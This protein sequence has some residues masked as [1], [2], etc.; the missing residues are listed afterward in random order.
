MNAAKRVWLA[1]GV[2]A[3]LL[4]GALAVRAVVRRHKA[5]PNVTET[6]ESGVA[7]AARKAVPLTVA[8]VVYDGKLNTGWDDWGW[9]PHKLGSG[10]AEV[11]FA[12]F[13]GI[14]LHHAELPGAEFG[15]VAFRYK[16]PSDWGHFMTVSLRR[17]GIPDDSFPTVLIDSRHLA[18]LEDGWREVLV[19]WKELNP[20]A[21]AF[22]RIM[23]GSRVQLDGDWVSLD[24]IVLTAAAGVVSEPSKRNAELRVLCKAPAQPINELIYGGSANAWE[25]GQSAQRFGGNPLSRY[26]WEL[27]AWNTGSDWY[28]ENIK[29]K[30]TLFDGIG[31]QLKG[32]HRTALV[33]P[34]LGWVA[35][36]GVS[37][38]FP[39]AKFG[40]QR[41]YDPY[42][43]EAGDGARPDGTL[44]APGSPEQTSL[45]APPELIESW[46]KKL[47]AQAAAAGHVGSPVDIYILDNEPALW[48]VTHRD[49]HPQPTSYD[50]L[51]DR[52]IKYAS[53]I[54]RADPAAVIAGPAE[55]G[56]LG[57]MNSAVDRVAGY[58]KQPDR[59]AHGGQALVAWYLKQLADHEKR[60]GTRLLDMLD[61]H[62]YPQATGMYGGEEATDARGS[63]L[64]LRSTRSLWDITYQ[65]ESWIKEA[66][67]LIPR[68]KDWVRENYPGLKISIGEWNFGAEGHISGGLAT[69][70][71]LGR[72]GQQ[73][74]DAAFHWGALE[75][76][77][78][79]YWAFRAFRNFDGSGGRF[80]DLSL[81][82]RESENLSLFASRDS[83]G[84][85]LVLVAINRSAGS[86]ANT[87]VALEGCGN[88][89]GLRVFKYSG[90][91]GIEQD[92]GEITAGGVSTQLGAY[93][94]AVFDIKLGDDSKAP[95]PR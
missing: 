77:K 68:M 52:T 18:E 56:W 87:N 40:E 75:K 58:D 23:I 88:V 21:D 79:A 35:K 39:R 33:V 29:Q 45:A 38:G 20:K 10:P 24:R 92:K 37:F 76:D 19:E 47:V 2:V 60:T 15:A 16:A 4:F 1:V 73:G 36:D 90:G 69:A 95:A 74:L 11:V 27:G 28:F 72:F 51:L 34:I 94:L 42:K 44:I 43:P 82:A 78:P 3:L 26:N 63:A 93:S 49:V 8:E 48:D 13:G 83:T 6:P 54:R 55:W 70:E 22:D 25:A 32:K 84:T 61:L 31:E 57:Y 9:G 85:H 71:A 67:R 46:V 81:P 41:K 50:E 5:A 66:I 65:D 86:E 64:R 17:N 14:L 53:A 91:K 62:Y 30:N 59:K 12:G 80:L 89:S 7:K